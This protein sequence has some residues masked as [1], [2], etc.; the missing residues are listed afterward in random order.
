MNPLTAHYK[1]GAVGSLNGLSALVFLA[2]PRIGFSSLGTSDFGLVIQPVLIGFFFCCEVISGSLAC[3]G[4]LG[5]GVGEAGQG[6][7]ELKW[8]A[9]V[10]HHENKFEAW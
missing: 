4:R 6:R 10:W 8:L 3:E 5:C 2:S 7:K 1:D 9:K